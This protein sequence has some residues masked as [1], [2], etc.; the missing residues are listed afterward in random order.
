MAYEVRLD[1]YEGP[2]G[3]LLTLIQSQSVDVYRISLSDLVRDFLAEIERRK[4]LDL[5]VAT[6]FLLVAAT[7]LEIKC[8]RLLPGGSD[9]EDDEETAFDD[10]RDVL[11]ARL[12]EAKTYRDVSATLGLMLAEGAKRHFRSAGFGPEVSHLVPDP[13]GLLSPTDILAA[14][15]GVLATQGVPPMPE[16]HVTPLPKMSVDDARAKIN[17]HLAAAGVSTFDALVSDSANRMEV[18]VQFLGILELYKLGEID[19]EQLVPADAITLRK[20]LATTAV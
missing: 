1:V 4:S 17:A 6:E 20:L 11:L 5:E 13:L 12:L 3:L 19:I 16:V 15:E 2:I 9:I 14:Y 10:E 8:R 7:L 18:V